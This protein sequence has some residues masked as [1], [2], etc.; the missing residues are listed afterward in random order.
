MY[1]KQ[2]RKKILINT[3]S[4]KLLGGV[5]N[6]F[7]GLNNFWNFKINYCYVGSRNGIN[8]ILLLP[9]DVLKFCLKI[10]FFQP[11]YI[12]I[13]PSLQ[14]NALK[15]DSI[16]L[17]VSKLLKKNTIIFFHGWDLEVQ[18]LIDNNKY[19]LLKNYNKADMFFVLA[20]SFKQKL[21]NWGFKQPIN[22][23]TTKVDDLLVSDF[24]IEKKKI[25]KS[26]LFLARI[27]K[28]KGIYLV[29]KTYKKLKKKYKDL[30]LT[31]V[32]DGNEL[33]N[34]KKYISE[35]KL[36]DVKVTG[37]LSGQSLKDEFIKNSLYF[38]PT[39]HGEGMPTSLLEAMAFGLTIVSRPVGG[40]SDFFKPEMGVLTESKDP[41][42]YF[43]ILDNYFTNENLL[44][45]TSTFNHKYA[46]SNFLASNVVQCLE[47]SLSKI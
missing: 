13:N 8:G 17:R 44:K 37:R 1:M 10:I 33:T 28:Q 5:S 20:S 14:V 18:K 35:N 27:E 24:I 41:E 36:N 30:S 4:L 7:M 6:H 15:R 23:T 38:F 31:I 12:L 29:L 11:D 3:P 16:F 25:T 2:N 45:E 9:I 32:G 39:Y 21:E 43:N 22:L 42:V 40:T 47:K 19:D 46:M 34:V 26:I